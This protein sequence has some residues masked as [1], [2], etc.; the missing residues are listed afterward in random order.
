MH[1]T[2]DTD[3]RLWTRVKTG[4]TR[5]IRI[6]R[7]VMRR[8]ITFIHNPENDGLGGNKATNR[9]VSKFTLNAK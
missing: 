8:K 5:L 9:S 2:L 6:D 7:Q 3:S 4:S 1:V